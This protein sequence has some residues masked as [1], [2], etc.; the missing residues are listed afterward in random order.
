MGTGS[1]DLKSQFLKNQKKPF[2]S[3]QEL[4]ANLDF[5]AMKKGLL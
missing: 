3:E 1:Q 2:P 5:T 4:A